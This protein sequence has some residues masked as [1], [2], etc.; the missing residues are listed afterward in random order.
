MTIFMN[1]TDAVGDAVTHGITRTERKLAAAL[2]TRA[3]VQFVM[4]HDGRLRS[5]SKGSTCRRLERRET[6]RVPRV[7]RFGVDP[8]PRSVG[9]TRALLT[10]AAMWRNSMNEAR[11]LAPL[12]VEQFVPSPGDVLISVGVDWIR[13][14]IDE[15][16]RLVFGH[17]VSYV[18]FC[19]DLIPL[20]HPEWLLP[21]DPSRFRE[22][23]DRL[24]RIASPVV[25]ISEQTRKDFRRHYPECDA[26]GIEVLTLGSDS[27][28]DP[29][30]EEL[31]FADSIFDGKPYAIYCATIDR[32][33]NHQL[34]Y[35]VVK[36]MS[37]RDIPSNIMLVGMI[38]SGVADLID[39][40]RHDPLIAGRI[41]HV[42]DCDDVQLS[43]LYERAA[44][45]VYPSLYEGWGLGVTE[46]LAHGKSCLIASGSSLG[47]AGLG[48]CR[49]LHPLKTAQWV[50][51]MS[52]YFSAPPAVPPISLP[53]WSDS[54]EALLQMVLP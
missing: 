44:F 51:A 49:E 19:Y 3:E 53:T 24:A 40:L 50:D 14:V 48:V 33:K 54:A 16:E 41:A 37:R 30:P 15:A 22:H 35:R 29:G 2:A 6:R 43:A 11:S 21:L 7:E 36:E 12:E 20:D 31:A 13:G 39:S 18:G 28:A 23:Y 46:A 52:E 17:S 5:I 47:E 4:M 1:V 25:C 26:N 10:S 42:T 34:L 27:G 38:G 45:A 32:R 8:I 9:R